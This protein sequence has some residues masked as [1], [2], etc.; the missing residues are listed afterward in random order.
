MLLVKVLRLTVDED[1]V[2]L[3]ELPEELLLSHDFFL[4]ESFRETNH[5]K[6]VR[7]DH[8]ELGEFGEALLLGL[9]QVVLVLW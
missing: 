1:S 8:S 4:P 7:D 6:K 9:A 5:V 3:A 2:N